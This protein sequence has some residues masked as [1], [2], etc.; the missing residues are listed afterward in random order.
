MFPRQRGGTPERVDVALREVEM[1]AG[2]SGV[3]AGRL[4][5][6]ENPGGRA[7]KLPSE[8]RSIK[9]PVPVANAL[10]AA[11]VATAEYTSLTM[12]GVND[13]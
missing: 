1:L 8:S 7:H 11:A 3:G 9:P 12:S 2:V 4:E 6:I 13:N 5:R 10:T